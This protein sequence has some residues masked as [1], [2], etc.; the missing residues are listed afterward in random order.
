M[1]G[2]APAASVP[3]IASAFRTSEPSAVSPRGLLRVLVLFHE[4]ELLGAG[5]SVLNA[6]NE[7]RRYGWSVSGWV[8]GPGEL[9]DAAAARLDAVV[10]APR[11]LAVSRRGWRLDPGVTARL[12]ATPGY[13]RALQVV[14]PRLRPHVVHANTLRTLPEALLVRRLGIPIVFHVHELPPATEKRTAALRLAARIGDA[15]VCVSEAVA[16]VVRPHAGRTPVLVAHNGVPLPDPPAR[17]AAHAFTVGT[18]GTV[19]RLKGT[20]I[21]FRAAARVLEQRPG[22][23]FEHAGE[24]S[25]PLDL[26]LQEEL[27]ALLAAP[28]LAAGARMLGR[29]DA[30]ALLPHWDAFVLPSRMDAFPLAT[31]E[32][33]AHAVPVIASRVGGIPEQVT[34]LE[35]GLLVDPGDTLALADR[36]VELHDDPE[37]RARLGEAGRTHVREHFSVRRQADELHRAYLLA[38][39]RRFGPPQVRAAAGR[40]A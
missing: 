30:A 16:E 36:I 5:N 9:A 8:P 23:R 29:V 39:N 19:S 11:P 15:V 26:E 7:L 12:R 13:F 35:N 32:A 10:G 2:H 18:I 20:D 21:F 31:L 24:P 3:T 25:L 40:T 34:H 37:L 17:T 4:P 6:S 33:M 28:P 1:T 14:L 27:Q 38:L 22:A